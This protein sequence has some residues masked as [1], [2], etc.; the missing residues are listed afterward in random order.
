MTDDMAVGMPARG[1]SAIGGRVIPP[2]SSARARSRDT[3]GATRQGRQL[4]GRVSFATSDGLLGPGRR[5]RYRRAS[6]ARFAAVW[7]A[8]VLLLPLAAGWAWGLLG[9]APH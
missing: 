1:W 6:W 7:L 8:V 4:T 9:S 3:A 5:L 2:S